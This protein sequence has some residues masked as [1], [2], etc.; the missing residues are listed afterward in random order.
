MHRFQCKI[1]AFQTLEIFRKLH[2]S[3]TRNDNRNRNYLICSVNH[4]WVFK[5]THS[6]ETFE[7][8]I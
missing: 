3:E 1:L 4:S 5:M 7:T 8:S 2:F 6:E